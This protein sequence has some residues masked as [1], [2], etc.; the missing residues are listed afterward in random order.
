MVRDFL[1]HWFFTNKPLLH[2]TFWL[3]V[4]REVSAVQRSTLQNSWQIFLRWLS[5]R[6]GNPEKS[7][8][9]EIFHFVLWIRTQ[10]CYLTHEEAEAAQKSRLQVQSRMI[11]ETVLLFII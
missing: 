5:L 2:N 4:E 8:T 7:H 6:Y 1:C 10:V 11:E 3:K 9:T